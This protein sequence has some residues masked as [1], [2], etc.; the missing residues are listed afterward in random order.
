MSFLEWHLADVF[1][2]TLGIPLLALLCLL[3]PSFRGR[4]DDERAGAFLAVALSYTVLLTL[5]VALFASRFVG[6]LAERQLV[7]AAPALFL[8]LGLW[9]DRGAPRPQPWTSLA[10]AVVAVPVV[11]LP[12]RVL[13]N[14]LTAHNS[15]MTVPL[16]KLQEHT[17][18]SI[19]Q[20]GYALLA[21]ALVAAFVLVPRRAAP[22]L[23][24]VVA[25]GLLTASGFAT[26]EVTRL[27]RKERAS[28]FSGADPEWVDR[29]ADGPVTVY[30][31]GE[32]TAT[33]VWQHVFWNDRIARVLTQPG[34]VIPG[35]LPQADAVPDGRGNVRRNG[36]PVRADLVLT[37]PSLTL[38]GERV[39]GI[40]T[41][42]DQPGLNLWRTD[43]PVRLLTATRGVLP[44]GDLVG[45]A[46]VRVYACGPGTLELTLIGKQGAPLRISRDGDPL[47]TRTIPSG[48][49]DH[50]SLPAPPGAKG[51]TSCVFELA[52]D[53]LLGSTRIE[54]VRDGP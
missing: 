36:L 4:E 51:E 35:P 23:L 1:L 40:P 22:A 50:L 3:E 18:A 29:T 13:S 17:S 52:S 46:T 26:A 32:R 24:A 39:G 15:F 27:S 47:L 12:V 33:D 10:A 21:A 8:A 37:S 9:L 44:N 41:S 38:Q 16:A 14:D 34:Y 42:I 11:L 43:G 19:L 28:V 49:V 53:G 5:E 2:V 31:T 20:T 25:V 6:H 45:P 54:F 7:T 48:R 30:A